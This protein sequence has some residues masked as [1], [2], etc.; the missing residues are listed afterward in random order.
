MPSHQ[1]RALPAPLTY[2]YSASYE[3]GSIKEGD[4]LFRNNNEGQYEGKCGHIH[5]LIKQGGKHQKRSTRSARS[6]YGRR[7]QPRL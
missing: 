3:L 4:V 6:T 5:A 2:I 7:V 1:A